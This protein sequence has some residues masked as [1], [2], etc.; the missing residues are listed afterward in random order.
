[1]KAEHLPP[2][3]MVDCSHANSEKKFAKQED[4]WH[5]VIEQRLGG[6]KSLIGM[7][8]ESHL[9]AGSQKFV[10]G[11]DDPAELE[12]GKSI[13]DA[14]LGWPLANLLGLWPRRAR[15]LPAAPREIVIVK[16][17]GLGSLLVCADTLARTI[18]APIQLPVGV[19]TALIGVPVFLYLLGRR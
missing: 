8:V 19:L 11:R 10:A 14:C 13:T 3:L 7:M 9:Q 1:M 17:F 16:L 2:V 18:V 4:V 12:Y 6:T 5:S 15:A